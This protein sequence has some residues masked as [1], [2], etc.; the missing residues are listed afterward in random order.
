MSSAKLTDQRKIYIR[1]AGVGN[2]MQLSGKTS[3]ILPDAPIITDAPRCN[4]SV[5]KD[6]G[7]N[8]PTQSCLFAEAIC[9]DLKDLKLCIKMAINLDKEPEPNPDA[10]DLD[11]A[12]Y[13]PDDS[14]N[15]EPPSHHCVAGP[16]RRIPLL[17]GPPPGSRRYLSASSFRDLEL[18]FDLGRHR[19]SFGY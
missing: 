13:D 4:N 9:G 8:R 2:M 5:W 10:R 18:Q 19:H 6:W 7:I 14:T 3:N 12:Y 11:A 15:A 1:G 17:S 16:A